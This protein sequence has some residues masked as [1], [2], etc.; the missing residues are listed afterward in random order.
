[1]EGELG[2]HFGDTLGNPLSEA[3]STLGF[4]SW[5]K[6][7][8]GTCFPPSSS[9]HKC[10]NADRLPLLHETETPLMHNRRSNPRIPGELSRERSKKLLRPLW[11]LGLIAYCLGDDEYISYWGPVALFVGV[12]VVLFPI[13]PNWRTLVISSVVAF[14]WF[15]IRFLL[16]LTV[17]RS[18][19]RPP[20]PRR[21]T[22]AFS[23]RP[24]D[25]VDPFAFD[26]R[27]PR[28][29]VSA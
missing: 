22:S 8:V 11:T 12:L 13:W 28:G 29:T 3:G 7:P 21:S 24:N 25:R 5:S 6:R 18:Y 20:P 4:I 26:T 27:Q 19:P 16:S 17:E 15:A 2:P 23:M 1:M 10:R 9:R 14:F